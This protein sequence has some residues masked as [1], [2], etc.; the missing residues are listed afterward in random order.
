M[1]PA[2]YGYRRDRYDARDRL[3]HSAAVRLPAAVDLRPHCPP[4]MDQGELGSCTA[5]GITGALRYELKLGGAADVAL[6]RLQLYYDER[7]SEGTVRQDAG[8]EIRDGIKCAGKIGVGREALWPYQVAKFRSKPPAKVYADAVQFEALSYERVA[9]G[10]DAI[11]AALASGFAVVIGVTL[12]E[13]FESQAV[14]RGGVVPMPVKGE[15][16]AGGHCMYVVG[17]GQRPGAFTVRNSWGAS[18]GDK[19]DCYMPEA[20]LG[21]TH[22]GSDYWVIKTAGRRS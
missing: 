8:A 22:Y 1:S 17:Y 5:H 16:V 13:S 15:A 9:V 4:V 3:F 21:S 20:Y 10:A 19:G 11:K 2:R 6:S 7:S 18:W 14:E 12:Y